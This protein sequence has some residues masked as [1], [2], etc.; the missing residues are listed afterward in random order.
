MTKQCESLDDYIDGNLAEQRKCEFEA[1]LK[2]CRQC[3]LEVA[4]AAE[5]DESLRGAWQSIRCATIERPLEAN[6]PGTGFLGQPLAVAIGAM[7]ASLAIGLV[8]LTWYLSFFAT[9]L[10]DATSGMSAGSPAVAS[11]RHSLIPKHSVLVQDDGSEDDAILMPTS[12]THNEFTIVKAYRPF[13]GQLSLEQPSI[14]EFHNG[15]PQ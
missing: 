14:K 7:A 12:R 1:H 13:N 5:L 11:D 6:A 8:A 10:D 2:M 15:N 3:Q 4:I 9:E